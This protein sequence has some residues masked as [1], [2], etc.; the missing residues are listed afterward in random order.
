MTD[1]LAAPDDFM[2]DTFPRKG[3]GGFYRNQAGECVVVHPKHANK[4]LIYDGASSLLDFGKPYQGDPIHGERGTHVHTLCGHALRGEQPPAELVAH[5]E[6]LGISAALQRHIYREFIAVRAAHGIGWA[7]IEE[8]VVH[9]GW[10]VATNVDVV[11]VM[12]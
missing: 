11:D 2:L 10:R 5:G 3:R 8:P 4:V 1:L 7:A 9:D 6:T 12:P